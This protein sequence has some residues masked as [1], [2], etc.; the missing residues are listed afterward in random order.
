MREHKLKIKVR[1]HETDKMG[2]VHHGNYINWF[3][4][5]RT[6]LCS[7]L[8]IP[9]S[10]I[11]KEGFN[12]AVVEATVRYLAPVFF[13]EEVFVI[14]KIEKASKS[15]FHFSY[16]IKNSKGDKIATGYTKHI[17]VNKQLKKD[18]LPD[19]FLNAFFKFLS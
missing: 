14:L 6:D 16:V 13:D 17:V 3:E 2:V 7:S 4:A 15:Y 9:Y 18:R 19:K 8:G 5:V 11:E 1:Y 10:L 12:I